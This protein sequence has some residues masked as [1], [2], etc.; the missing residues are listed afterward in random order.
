MFPFSFV[1]SDKLTRFFLVPFSFSVKSVLWLYFSHTLLPWQQMAESILG[2]MSG[3]SVVFQNK[4]PHAAWDKTGSDV[5]RRL[6]TLANNWRISLKVKRRLM[7]EYGKRPPGA[8]WVLRPLFVR[9]E[10]CEGA[11]FVFI[12][13]IVCHHHRYCCSRHSRLLLPLCSCRFCRQLCHFQQCLRRCSLFHLCFLSL[14]SFL[15]SSSSSSSSSPSALSFSFLSSSLFSSL[16]VIVFLVLLPLAFF[17][18]LCR[19][20][21]CCFHHHRRL[22]PLCSCRRFRRHLCRY[23]RHFPAFLSL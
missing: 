22:H 19:H 3:F 1:I 7:S 4:R 8:F 2:S 14:P 17:V 23:L 20:G 5:R 6:E 10:N 15:L 12:T 13:F 11:I 18:D 9:M 16:S 21:F